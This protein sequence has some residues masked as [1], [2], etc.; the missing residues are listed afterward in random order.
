MTD[1]KKRQPRAKVAVLGSREEAILRE[2]ELSR[3]L[4]ELG[5]TD[6]RLT[7][8]LEKVAEKFAPEL[9]ELQK[10]IFAA[11]KELFL[12]CSTNRAELTEEG[13]AKTIRLAAIGT[14]RFYDTPPAVSLEKEVEEPDVIAQMKALGLESFIRIKEEI[15]REALLKE[16]EKAGSIKGVTIDRDEK[17]AI[18]PDNSPMRVEHSKRTNRWKIVTK[19]EDKEAA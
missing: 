19:K 2:T 9:E 6:A 8:Q 18:Q 10:G 12:Y 14:M 13:R 5:A 1:R 15:D 7:A 11:S 17:F 4:V 3:L 16:P